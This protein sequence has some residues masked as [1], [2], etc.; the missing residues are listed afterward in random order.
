MESERRSGISLLEVLTVLAIVVVLVALMLPAMLQAREAARRTQCRNNLNQ[1]SLAIGN[2]VAAFDMLPPGWIGVRDLEHAATGKSGAAWGMLMLAQ[3]DQGQ[4]LGAFEAEG[5]VRDARNQ[6][7]VS[8]ALPT[9]VCPSDELASN[10]TVTVG[11]HTVGV[12]TYVTVFGTGNPEG[13]LNEPGEAPVS[14]NGQCRGNGAFFHN[15]STSFR[16]F[17]DGLSNTVLI[18]ERSSNMQLDVWSTWTGV[19]ASDSYPVSR[20]VGST[21]SPLRTKLDPSAFGGNH[22]NGTP[23]SFADGHSKMI[24]HDVDFEVYQGMSTIGGGEF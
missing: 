20:I 10:P 13:C 1:L 8:T 2:Y 12:T 7:A 18:G 19:F 3:I 11:N 17:T 22:A 6:A 15:S 16:Q 23:F 21:H 24:S 4:L 14:R 5:S 9:Y